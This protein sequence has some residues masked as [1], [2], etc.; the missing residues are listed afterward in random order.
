[1]TPRRAGEPE[2][3]LLSFSLI[4][5]ALRSGPAERAELLATADR[6]LVL[7]LRLTEGR[8]ARRMALVRG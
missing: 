6:T 8:Y 5:R 3:D 1:M 2:A 7:L 4:H